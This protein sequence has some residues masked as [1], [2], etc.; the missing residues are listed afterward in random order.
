MDETTPSNH[1][2]TIA[3]V[4]RNIGLPLLFA[5]LVTYVCQH[6]LFFKAYVPTG[7][8][9]PTIM[10]EDRLFVTYL[11]DLS[12]LERGDIVVFNSREYGN[13]FV[14]RLIGLGG[15]TVVIE[16]DGSVWINGEYLEEPYVIY[17]ETSL[18][19]QRF[20]IPEGSYLFLGDNRQNSLDARYWQE[21]YISAQDVLGI[22]R[23]RFYP[24]SQFKWL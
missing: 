12:T 20:E 18:E 22:A 5:I 9:I 1:Q 4:W 17:P 2:S 23:F 3:W 10:P 21:P 13:C 6:Y 19:S 11:H 24:L 8:M 15:E 7:S 16:S 14:K